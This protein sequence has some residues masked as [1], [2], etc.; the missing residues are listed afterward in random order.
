MKFENYLKKNTNKQI[1]REVDNV[2]YFMYFIT[3]D[4]QNNKQIG[5]RNVCWV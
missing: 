3:V 2:Q 4:I 5:S 1:N